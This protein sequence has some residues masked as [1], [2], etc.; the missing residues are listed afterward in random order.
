M[1]YD[2]AKIIQRMNDG[3][4]KVFNYPGV[5]HYVNQIEAFSDTVLNS[6][7]YPCSLEFSQGTQAMI[8]SIFDFA[9]G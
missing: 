3:T 1:V 9:A 6:K 5:S 2:K 8:D 4:E 7:T